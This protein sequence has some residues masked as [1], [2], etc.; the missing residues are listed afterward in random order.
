[1]DEGLLSIISTGSYRLNCM[2]YFDQI[3][4][5]YLFQHCP[6]SGMQNGD[7]ALPSVILAGLGLIDKYLII[8]EPHYIV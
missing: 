8:L 6:A 1:M 2:L 7:E 5:T 3:L 4:H